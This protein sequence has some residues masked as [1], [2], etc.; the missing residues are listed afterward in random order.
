MRA[1]RNLVLAVD[2]LGLF[3]P[4]GTAGALPAAITSAMI[5]GSHEG[6][7]FCGPAQI[8]SLVHFIARSNASRIRWFRTTEKN[9]LQ[10]AQGH[11]PRQLV[12]SL[13]SRPGYLCI[14]P[15]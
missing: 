1:V 15:S 6:L 8:P 12:D 13:P 9:S 10:A 7:L 11:M 2:E 3:I 4:S 5:S 14:V